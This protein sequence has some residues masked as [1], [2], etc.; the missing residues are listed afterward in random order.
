AARRDRGRRPARRLPPPP[1]GAGRPAPPAPPPGGG[2]RRPPPRLWAPR[3]RGG[4]GLPR[5]A[6]G[7]GGGLGPTARWTDRTAGD[8][9]GVMRSRPRSIA[10]I[11][12]T[13]AVCVAPGS[14]APAAPT[15]A[16]AAARAATAASPEVPPA[17]GAPAAAGS[18][19]IV[20]GSVDRTSLDLRT[21]YDVELKLNYTR[22][23]LSAVSTMLVTNESGGPVDRLELNAV[24]ARLG[25]LAISSLTVDGVA[26]S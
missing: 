26:V 14:V 9:L 24:A 2:G 22:R 17:H 23:T 25:R 4:A 6:P 1:R 18:S 16:T 20:P 13:L 5:S 8:R 3:Q 7:G 21:A 12:L 10:T 11:A 19:A 15:A